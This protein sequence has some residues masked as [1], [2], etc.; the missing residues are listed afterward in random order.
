MAKKDMKAALG[1]T[2]KAE[3]TAVKQ[4]FEKAEAAFKSVEAARSKPVPKPEPA[5]TPEKVIRDAFTMPK[6]DYVLIA[7]IKERCLKAGISTTKSEILRAGVNAL[8][9]MSDTG[10]KNAILMLSKVKTGRPKR[11]PKE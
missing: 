4:R 9:Q 7:K 10:L 11:S 2:L 3:E 6:S 8:F 1:A 5:K